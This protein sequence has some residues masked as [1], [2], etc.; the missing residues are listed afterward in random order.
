M[1]YNEE[2]AL[3]GLEHDL[4]SRLRAVRVR[5][6]TIA[7]EATQDKKSLRHFVRTRASTKCWT[8]Y[9]WFFAS[10]HSALPDEPGVYVVYIDGA[11]VYIGSS[12]TSV[13]TRVHSHGL[14]VRGYGNAITTPW[15]SAQDLIVKVR[16][17]RSYGDWLAIEARLIRRLRPPFNILHSGK[18][19]K[20]DGALVG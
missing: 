20:R 5:L 4:L 18:A 1:P 19:Q 11:L 8:T 16:S 9:D 10:V 17:C 12:S 2:D 14:T 3:R 6:D 15:G 13:K 7:A